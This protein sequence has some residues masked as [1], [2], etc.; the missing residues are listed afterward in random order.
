M[1]SDMELDFTQPPPQVNTLDEARAVIAALWV[2]CAECAEISALKKQIAAQQKEIESLKE[3]LNTNSNNSSNPPCQIV[4]WRKVC[5]GTWSENGSLYLARVMGVVATCRLQ[6]RS[7]FGFLCESLQTYM[8]G[9]PAPSLL[10]V[11]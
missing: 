7:V 10:P 9:Q 3:K 8:T 6:K 1:L 5:F 4:I 11:A 2:L